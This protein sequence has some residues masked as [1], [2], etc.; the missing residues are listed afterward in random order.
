MVAGSAS[1]L[2]QDGSNVGPAAA[3]PWCEMNSGEPKSILSLTRTSP[4]KKSRGT[5]PPAQRL[6][7]IGTLASGV[8]HDLNNIL[9][10][11]LMA[12][13]LLRDDMPPGRTG[14]LL[15]IVQSSAERGAS[16]VKQVLDFCAWRGWRPRPTATHLFGP[17]DRENCRRK[18]FPKSVRRSDQLSRR[19]LDDRGESHATS[20]G[21]AQPLHQRARCDAH[22]R[23]THACHWKISRSTITMPAWSPGAKCR[24][25]I[26][27]LRSR[28]T[29]VAFPRR[30]IDKIFDPFFTTKE[31][32]HGTGLGLSTVIGIVQVMGGSWRWRAR[33]DVARLLK[34][35]SRK[36]TELRGHA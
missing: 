18:H 22:R 8:A 17:G 21:S 4:S 29:G 31:I 24:A 6:E 26:C 14:K 1:N 33:W 35:F 15:G 30:V 28:D 5:I 23:H 10:P 11:I 2:H 36:S 34:S 7:S 19:P 16:I 3:G 13:P 12:A 32:G 27:S 20:S 25:R 9:V